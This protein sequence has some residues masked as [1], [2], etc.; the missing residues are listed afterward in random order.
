MVK[1][2]LEQVP[3][4][5]LALVAAVVLL[6]AILGFSSAFY[7]GLAV[8]AVAALAVLAFALATWLP[9]RYGEGPDKG[10]LKEQEKLRQEHEGD[11]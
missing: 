10:E 7:V 9:K 4:W 8:L 2:A 5:A 3:A 6:L 1:E 11:E